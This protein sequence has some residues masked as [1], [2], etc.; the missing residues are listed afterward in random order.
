ME[1]G[2]VESFIGLGSGH[3]KTCASVCADF[4]GELEEDVGGRP[5]LSKRTLLSG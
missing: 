3:G 2:N 4:L 5:F 1:E